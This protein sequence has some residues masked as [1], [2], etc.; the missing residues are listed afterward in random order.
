MTIGPLQNSYPIRSTAATTSSVRSGADSKDLAAAY[1]GRFGPMVAARIHIWP[2]QSMASSTAPRSRLCVGTI[3]ARRQHC[4]TGSG[5]GRSV[6]SARREDD[7]FGERLYAILWTREGPG[8]R[9]E[10]LEFRSVTAG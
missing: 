9:G 3:E 4:A 6:T 8:R 10:D 1:V 7:L 2:T 5:H